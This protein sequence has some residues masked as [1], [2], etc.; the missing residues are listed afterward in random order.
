MSVYAVVEFYTMFH[1]TPPGKH[2]I[3]MCRTLSCTMRGCEDLQALVT[4]KTGIK[5]GEK[6][7]DGMFSLEMVE[8]LGSCGTA[9]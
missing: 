8:C 5:P 1:T 3:M 7:K 9:P 4:E 2:H 6:S